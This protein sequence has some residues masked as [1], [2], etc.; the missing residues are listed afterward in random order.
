MSVYQ[1]IKNFGGK[2]SLVGGL[3]AVLSGC[4]NT[5]VTYKKSQEFKDLNGDGKPESISL[6]YD[7]RFW[8]EGEHKRATH[9]LRAQHPDYLLMFA[10]GVG[11]GR[12][13][14]PREVKRYHG[15][16]AGLH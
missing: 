7:D 14:E 5:Y 4:G 10:K 13:R 2:A 9:N 8:D 16:P 1:S 15:K 3:A 6:V 11:D 12:F